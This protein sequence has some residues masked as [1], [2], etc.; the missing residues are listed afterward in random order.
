MLRSSRGTAMT[1]LAVMFPNDGSPHI[2]TPQ[3]RVRSGTLP[4]GITAKMD[5]FARYA[6][7]GMSLAD[8]YRQ[9][10]NT[11]NMKARTISNEASRL[12]ANP[13]VTAAIKAYRAE[14]EAQ[15][16]MSALGRSE[17]IWER[18]WEL[19]DGIDV[20]P[21]VKV[22]ALDLAARLVGMFKTP[23]TEDTLSAAQI[24]S[25]LRYRLGGLLERSAVD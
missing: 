22:K 18:L 8:A 4:S 14:F 7:E 5:I 13:G 3:T 16:R 17:R 24:E 20:P 21:A 23:G 6:A 11:A 2:Q 25:E 19:V 15:S 1:N 9:A 10:F 12:V